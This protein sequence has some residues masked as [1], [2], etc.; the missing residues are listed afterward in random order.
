MVILAGFYLDIWAA[1]LVWDCYTPL[2]KAIV[3]TG[4]SSSAYNSLT[5]VANTV[6][7]LNIVP[8]EIKRL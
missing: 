5:E 2:S 3:Y 7:P 6:E 8:W 4:I 1:R